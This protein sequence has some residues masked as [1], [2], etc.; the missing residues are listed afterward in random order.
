MQPQNLSRVGCLSEFP[1]PLRVK[2]QMG[3]AD[4]AGL[5]NL[6]GEVAF[7]LEEIKEKDLR[8][9][10]KFMRAQINGSRAYM[11]E[12]L[13][14]INT[15]HFGLTKHAR[16]SIKDK[17]K[18]PSSATGSS[19]PPFPLPLPPGTPLPT[20]HL[21]SKDAQAL[22]KIASEFAKVQALQDEKIALA[23]RMERITGRA[24]ER[25]RA[26][27]LKVGGMDL[28]EVEKLREGEES[29]GREEIAGGMVLLPSM[30]LGTGERPKSKSCLVL[31]RHK[32]SG[33]GGYCCD[34]EY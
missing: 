31:L 5:D 16:S 11:P 8:I 22:T 30:G 19:T 7:L 21:S 9:N 24:K 3:S 28:E 33:R 1:R 18:D 4:S 34:S 6:P 27:W 20:A 15:R 10:R 26:E 12:L 25:G 32:P 13:S 14:R 29:R 17:D 2:S 23:E